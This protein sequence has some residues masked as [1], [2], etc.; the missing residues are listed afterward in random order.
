MNK[1]RGSNNKKSSAKTFSS[2]EKF[3]LFDKKVLFWGIILVIL[4]LTIFFIFSKLIGNSV[5]GNVIS[6][7]GVFEDLFSGWKTGSWGKDADLVVAKIL[8]SLIIFCL[9]SASLNMAQFPPYPAIRG[10]IAVAASILATIY[11]TPAE[12]LSALTGYTTLGLVFSY[13]LP[14]IIL[15]FFS[16]M[17]VNNP[18]TSRI[19]VPNIV[20]ELFVW[21]FFVVIL[22]YK[23]IVGIAQGS[24]P[25]ELNLIAAIT[26][27]VFTLSSLILIF[28]KHFR[29]WIWGLSAQ[30]KLYQQRD[31]DQSAT[32][33]LILEKKLKAIQED[34]DKNKRPK[35]TKKK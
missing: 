33:A 28:N 22:G 23:I 25:L 10:I 35:K 8:F 1:K 30:L 14:F 32:N 9:I 7:N 6:G 27:G 16:I 26:L 24:L 19:S 12:V 11:L 5:N 4:F 17:L 34:I 18:N 2:Q 31:L 13:V 20:L 3:L 29:A 15:V 21:I